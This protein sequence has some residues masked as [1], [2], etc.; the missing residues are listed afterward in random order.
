MKLSTWGKFQTN[1][2]RCA[3]SLMECVWGVD[4]A[5]RV[6]NREK[7]LHARC[8]IFKL[9]LLRFTYLVLSNLIINL[10][11]AA[12]N[13]SPL[14]SFIVKWRLQKGLIIREYP[15]FTLS[16]HIH[17]QVD[18]VLETGSLN[19]VQRVLLSC[20]SEQKKRYEQ[21]NTKW[22]EKKEEFF[23]R[24]DKMVCARSANDKVIRCIITSMSM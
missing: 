12:S 13:C 14:N 9:W 11:Y 6:K 10:S 2:F 1:T 16:T 23:I 4:A 21:Q 20:W 17:T 8:Y 7:E 18:N 3:I 24:S 22:T 15:N 19:G 5:L